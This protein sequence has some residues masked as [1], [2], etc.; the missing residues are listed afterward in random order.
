MKKSK[1]FEGIIK[2]P[3]SILRGGFG[4]FEI[5]C[6]AFETEIINPFLK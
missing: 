5:L 2:L 1:D 4:F 6:K 3:D